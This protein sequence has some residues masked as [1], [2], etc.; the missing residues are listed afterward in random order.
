MRVVISLTSIPGREELLGRALASVLAQTYPADAIYLW[1]PDGY[2]RDRLP[3]ISHSVPRLRIGCCEDLGPATKLLPTLFQECD[4]ETAIVT[5]DDDIEYGPSVVEKLVQGALLHPGAAIGFTG[6]QVVG[7][8]GD[9]KVYHFDDALPE[10]AMFQPVDVIEGYRGAIYRRG[11][12]GSDVFAQLRTLQ[13][14]RLHDDILFGGHLAS[15]KIPR[16]VRW[17]N[18]GSQQLPWPWKLHGEETGLHTRPGWRDRGEECYA[19]FRRAFGMDSHVHPGLE[20]SDRL[21]LNAGSAVRRGFSAHGGVSGQPAACGSVR[22]ELSCFPWPWEDGRFREVLATADVPTDERFCRWVLECARI[23]KPNGT[24]MVTLPRSAVPWL[25]VQYGR[26]HWFTLLELCMDRGGAG[27]GSG[28][29][30][31]TAY[32]SPAVIEYDRDQLSMILVRR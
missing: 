1:L 7:D 13:A 16:L 11:F 23:T 31:C 28:L 5:L 12:F 15:H 22:A 14:F 10:C 18:C 24:A 25:E 19:Y 6:W 30:A 27:S 9:A 2:R 17:Y 4:P 29:A 20:A 26:G 3:A 32:D 8:G 21:H